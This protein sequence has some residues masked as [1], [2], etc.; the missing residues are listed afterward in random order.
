MK[1][2]NK[3]K[4]FI[5]SPYT[6]GDVAQNVRTQIDMANTLMNNDLIPFVPLYSHFQHMIHPR[7]YNDWIA[8]D[9]TWLETCDCVLRLPGES[10]GGD[11]EVKHAISLGKPVFYSTDEL[12]QYFNLI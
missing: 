10:K 3:I 4:V 11:I 5:S 6:K 1:T 7:P 12:F 9:L 2:A 8:V